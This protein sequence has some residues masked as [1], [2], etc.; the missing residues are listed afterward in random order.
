MIKGKVLVQED[1]EQGLRDFY[2]NENVVDGVYK[3]DDEF[4]GVVINGNEFILELNN[5]IFEMIKNILQ[6]KTLGVN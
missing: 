5:S 4:M 2:F 6:L 3:I 1:E